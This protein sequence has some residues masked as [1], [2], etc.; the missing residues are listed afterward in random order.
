MPASKRAI[1]SLL[2][3]SAFAAWAMPVAP[4]V[5]AEE[6]FHWIDEDGSVN[7]SDTRPVHDAPVTVIE[8]ETAPAKPYDP[9]EDPYSILN[10]AAR[11]HERWLDLE[12]ARRA[13]EEAEGDTVVYRDAPP[14]DYDDDGYLHYGTWY[15]NSVYWPLNGA[16]Y[17]PGQGRQQI[18]AMHT[19][20]LL[21]PRP[22]SINSG[23]HQ[24]RVYRSQFLPLVPAPPVVQPVAR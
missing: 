4:R 5:S 3:A 15:P 16:A 9:E 20:D 17:R 2:F 1:R 13:R 24:Q 7:F 14:Y 18:Y 11:Q 21:G 22:S 12:E 6:I 19:L 23:A 10:Q 8:I